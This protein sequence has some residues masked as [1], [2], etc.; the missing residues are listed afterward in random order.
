MRKMMMFMQPMMLA[1]CSGVCPDSVVAPMLAPY[2]SSSST[3]MILFFLQAMCKGVDPLRA[4]ELESPFLC[5]SSLAA[6]NFHTQS[7]EVVNSHLVY[8][9]LESSE[10]IRYQHL[11]EDS[12]SL[13]ET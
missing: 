1:T 7:S 4:R 2:L 6:V 5:S 12:Q 13:R 8:Q 11:A 3:T 10:T 9:G